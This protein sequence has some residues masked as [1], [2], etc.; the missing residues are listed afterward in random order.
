M[1]AADA[2]QD[3]PDMAGRP[4]VKP[5]WARLRRRVRR[6]ALKRRSALL[7]SEGQALAIAIFVVMMITVAVMS[8]MLAVGNNALSASQASSTLAAQLA[9]TSAANWAAAEIERTCQGASGNLG[10]GYSIG[11]GQPCVLLHG[12]SLS[13]GGAAL[14]KWM[15]L[16]SGGGT[17]ANFAAPCAV[18]G[19]SLPTTSTTSTT[20]TLPFPQGA[21]SRRGGPTGVASV[22][23]AGGAA[24][25]SGVAS[26][27]VTGG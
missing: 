8:T 6:F 5:D 13:P 22:A 26:V 9:A 11:A 19:P 4:R 14:D 23:P 2:R 20:S 24:G 18:L 15:S 21:A 3:A 25:P 16:P 10:Y 17:A 27:S 7:R 1:A 12:Q